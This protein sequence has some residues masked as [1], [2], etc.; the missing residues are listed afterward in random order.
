[1]NGDVRDYLFQDCGA[2]FFLLLD[3]CDFGLCS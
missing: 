2:A 3:E 1:M